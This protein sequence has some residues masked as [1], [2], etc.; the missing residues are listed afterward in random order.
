MKRK[1]PKMNNTPVAANTPDSTIPATSGAPGAAGTL[2]APASAGKMDVVSA[3]NNLKQIVHAYR[4]ANFE[5]FT[6]IKAS[7]ESVFDRLV[8]ADKFEQELTA[9]TKQ[10]APAENASQTDTA[11]A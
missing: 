8:D 10:A 2:A 11:Q 1:K 4:G 5:E 3:W 9:L 7:L 6:W